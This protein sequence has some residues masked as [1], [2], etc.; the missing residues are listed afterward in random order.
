MEFVAT[1][2]PRP[3]ARILA[4]GYHSVAQ[5]CGLSFAKKRPITLAV[6]VKREGSSLRTESF[7]PCLS[8]GIWKN[9]KQECS[10]VNTADIRKYN[11]STVWQTKSEMAT[12]DIGISQGVDT[13]GWLQQGKVLICLSGADHITLQKGKEQETGFFLKELG[14]PLIKLLENGFD[15]VFANPTG[16]APKMDPMSDSSIWFLKLWSELKKEKA[17]LHKMEVE[18]NFNSPRKFSSIKDEEL[19]Q[20]IGVLLPG[21]HAPMADLWQDVDLGRILLH[22]HYLNKPTGMIC[23]APIA[24]LSTKQVEFNKPWAYKGYKLTCYSNEEEKLNEKMWGQNLPYKVE[25]ELRKNGGILEEAFPM[26]PKVTTDRE[27]ITAQGPTSA[28]KF[29]EVFLEA[30]NVELS[31]KSNAR[32]AQS[33]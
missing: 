32:M 13:G 22:F 21:G 24:L 30:L 16:E 8:Q 23:H 6:T 19:N 33:N 29:G 4:Q 25:T 5:D 27:L 26:L 15:V 2:N 7:I 28:D 1:Q 20:F 18:K 3:V 12:P 31:K 10:K 14:R 9:N 11:N 17:V